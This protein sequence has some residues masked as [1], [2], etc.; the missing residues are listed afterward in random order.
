M[1]LTVNHTRHSPSFGGSGNSRAARLDNHKRAAEAL[2]DL[3]NY[4]DYRL[5]KLLASIGGKADQ[6]YSGGLLSACVCQQTEVFVFG[7][8]D[9]I[10]RTGDRED[11]IVFGSRFDFSH[12]GHVVTGIA[13]SADDSEIATLVG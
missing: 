11:G 9:T 13:E 8:Q 3:R 4:V 6:D 5:T 2:P 7:Q 1:P 10:L 12:G